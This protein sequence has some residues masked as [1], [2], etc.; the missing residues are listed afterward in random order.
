MKKIN[1]A[2]LVKGDI[3]LST[4]PG[5]LSALIKDRTDSDISHA[6]IY[7]ADGSVMDSTNEGVQARNIQKMFYEDECAIYAYRLK[8]D[9][10]PA[11]ANKI[12]NYVRAETGAPYTT[13]EAGRSILNPKTNGGKDQFCSRLVARAYESIGIR[14]TENPNFATPAQIK[15]SDLLDSVPNVVQNVSESEIESLEA[16]GDK[17][18]Q[19]REVTSA[20]LEKIRKMAPKVRVLNDIQI[21]LQANPKFDKKFLAAYK[22]SGY[23]DFWLVEVQNFPWRYDYNEML[24]YYHD[25]VDKSVVLDYCRATIKQNEQGDYNHWIGNLEAHKRLYASLPLKTFGQLAILYHNLVE[26][27]IKR[28]ENSKRLVHEFAS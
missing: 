16:H 26:H 17:T 28:L 19:M 12:I 7:V 2:Q 13:L 9:L 1:T 10:S 5:K 6:M 3:I 11:D 25:S 15:L 18:E 8:G 22:Q 20:L 27:Q 4:S 21:F 23:L 24:R 14:L